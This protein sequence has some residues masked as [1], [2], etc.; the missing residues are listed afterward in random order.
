MNSIQVETPLKKYT[1]HFEASFEPLREQIL[2]LRKNYSKI[3]IISDDHVAPLYTS[4]VKN[5]LEGLN[6]EVLSFDFAHGEVNKNYKSINL[7]YDFLITHQFD[8]QSLLIAL[9]GGVVGDMVGFTAATYMRGIDFIQVPTSLLA[10]VDSSIGGK[11]GIDFNGYK[12]IVGAF[13]QPEMVFINT[14]TLRTL[15]VQ[16]FAS[17]MG[18]VIKHSLI[19]DEAYMSFLESRVDDIKSLNHE[20][21]TALIKTSCLIKSDIVSKDEKEQ[22]LRATLNFGHTIGHAI[23]RLMDFERL[24]GECVA[25]GMMAASY[26]SYI[27]GD[28]T[29]QDLDRISSLMGLYD[30]PIGIADLS[31]EA[32]YK[33]LFFDKKTKHHQL[34]FVLLKRI[35]T[36]YMDNNIEEKLI[37]EGIK[38]ILN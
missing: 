7:I 23:E 31:P 38:A 22:G 8:R 32:I 17:G 18:E 10:Q 24:H 33:E 14:K 35:G 19:K 9:G 26:I 21:I 1:I 12:N 13:H 3:A 15:P 29:Q 30:L 36:C 37:M 5:T 34:S 6:I 11:T 16:E 4:E 27:L 2:K 20:A 25:L 28:L